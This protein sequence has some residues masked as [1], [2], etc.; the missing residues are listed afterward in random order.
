MSSAWTSESWTAASLDKLQRG[1]HIL[2]G[3]ENWI[4]RE[5]SEF[6]E[7]AVASVPDF[8]KGLFLDAVV[9]FLEID[10]FIY[11]ES[12]ALPP[13]LFHPAPKRVLIEGGGDGLI[14]RELLRDPRVEEI[15]MV[16]IDGLV[17]DACKEHLKELHR[18][19]FHDTR[20]KILVQDVFPY[21]EG[22]PEPFDVIIVDLLDGYDELAVDLYAKVLRLTQKALAPGGIVGA[23]GDLAIPRMS[24]APVYQG[25]K[26]HFERVVL[27]RASV[28]TFSGG[29]G[30]ML[31]SNDVDFEAAPTEQ[32][33]E[34][35]DALSGELRALTPAA[36]PSC[37]AVPGYIGAAIERP[38]PP[39][40]STLGETFKWLESKDP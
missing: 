12:A 9:E 3:I 13:L 15:V 22:S 38:A 7:V 35:A 5:R 20:A 27:H 11:H 24:I 34:R 21:L 6:Q 16:E 31:A 29:Y 33:L 32:I 17:I 40:S 19:S 37:F 2:L 26:S 28:Q 1:R 14:L 39:P 8:G 4:F 25:L 10:E 30:F 36:F 23:F 18:G